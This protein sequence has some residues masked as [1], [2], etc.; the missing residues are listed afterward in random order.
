VNHEGKKVV[1]SPRDL[2]TAENLAKFECPWDDKVPTAFFRGT[3]TGGGVT[4]ETNQRLR[5]AQLSY[6]WSSVGESSP[7]LLDAKLTGWNFRDK[8]IYSSELS[9]IDKTAFRFKVGTENFTPIYQQSRY[10][11]LLY[12]EGHCAACRYGFMMCLGSVILK[13]DSTCVA[14]KMW[15]F[16]LL[17]PY[18]DHVPVK[19]DFS[20][21]REKIEWCRTN[22]AKCQEIAENAK[23]LY[24]KF[25]SREGILDYMQAT[26]FEIGKR[27]RRF[28]SWA[29]GAPPA[30]PPPVKY[31]QFSVG[32]SCFKDGL[33]IMCETLKSSED[34]VRRTNSEESES[35]SRSANEEK[36]LDKKRNLD[37]MREKVA[38]KKRAKLD[39]V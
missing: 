1:K 19:A 32:S 13:V 5:V 23:A 22:D 16:P 20:D 30:L 6:D 8:K 10:K 35:K 29:K 17:R 4:V 25:I 34:Q 39:K 37:R 15:Y 3:A 28:P 2:F 31:S 14:D 26:M 18:F 21:L 36:A 24:S 9:Y 33:C 38:E 12:I 11:Y 7:P 27:Y